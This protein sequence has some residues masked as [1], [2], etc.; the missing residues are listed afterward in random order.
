[1]L[2]SPVTYARGR[3]AA[4]SQPVC[5]TDGVGWPAMFKEIVCDCGWSARGTEDELV[6]AA[7]EHGRVAHDL[8]PTREQ[9]LAVATPVA[10]T[11]E[12]E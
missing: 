3:R 5:N 2:S 9:V 11:D 7:Q 10:P 8:V 1:M 12:E 6:A 4:G